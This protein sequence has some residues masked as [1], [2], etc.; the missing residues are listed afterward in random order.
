MQE[1][2]KALTDSELALSV[3]PGWVK[4][5][6]RKGKA[7]AGLKVKELIR[8]TCKRH[9]DQYDVICYCL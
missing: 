1:Y 5:L 9:G 4:G 7:L 3:S 2:E 8:D 6:F